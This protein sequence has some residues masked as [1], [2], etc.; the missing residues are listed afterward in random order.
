MKFRNA[1]FAVM[2]CLVA[3]VTTIAFALPA[4]ADRALH[5]AFVSGRGPADALVGQSITSSPFNPTA[6]GKV[7]VELLNTANNRVTNLPVTITLT[8]RLDSVSAAGLTTT[9][10]TTFQGVATFD[11][12]SVGVTNVAAFSNYTLVAASDPDIATA[13]SG[14]F[15][16][17]EAG[18]NCGGGTCALN[19]PTVGD[20]IPDTYRISNSTAGSV[21]TAST[22]SVSDSNVDCD[23]YEEFT[24]FVVWHEYSG[25]G[26][27]F[28]VIHTARD[29]MK[30]DVR[31]GQTSVQLCVG[32]SHTWNAQQVSGF[33][34]QPVQ[35]DTN[36][37]APGGLL[38]VGLAPKCPK[39]APENGAPCI[40]RQ[41]G[42]GNG[43]N[44]TE[45]WLPGGDPPRRT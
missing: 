18:T 10:A 7:Q 4:N 21:I 17:W 28:V 37:S 43:G 39:K 27:V 12:L 45:A 3:S 1:R 16:I 29:E 8:L 24:S 41:Y 30:A 38:F 15:D 33:P 25:S 40:T 44:Y 14:G 42:D 5:L 35:K 22:F 32:L 2:L 19:L 6:A 36:G 13:T 34:S 23:G 20:P 31:N 9:P 11:P 26:K